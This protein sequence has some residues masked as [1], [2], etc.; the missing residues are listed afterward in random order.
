ATARYSVSRNSIGFTPHRRQ[1]AMTT[2]HRKNVSRRD[3]L[4]TASVGAIALSATELQADDKAVLPQKVLGKTGVKVPLIGLGTA[5]A[6]YR[7]EKEA[8]A[9]YH[10]CIDS[11]IAYLDT[12]PEFAGYGKAQVYLGQVLKERRKEVFLVTK[13]WEPDGEKALALLKKNLAELQTDH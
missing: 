8:V 10:K 2:S 13:C 1:A 3:F 6:G 11:G 9:F 12:A 7:P 4:K 5:P